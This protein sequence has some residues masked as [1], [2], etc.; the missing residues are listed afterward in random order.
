MKKS[1]IFSILFLL[2]LTACIT[3]ITIPEETGTIQVFF[4]P[5]DNCEQVMIDAISSASAVKCAFYDLDLENLTKT[6]KEKNADILMDEDN[7]E[8]YGKEISGYGLMHN[9]F[10]ILDEK[11]IITG[12]MNPTMRGAYKNNNNLVIIESPTLVNNYLA[13]FD[14][15]KQG[16]SDKKT[17]TTELI[18]N[19]RSLQNFFCPDDLCEEK[20]LTELSKANSSIYFLT[21]SFTSDPIGDLLVD[22]RK[23]IQIK[24]IFEKSQNSKWS[25]RKNSTCSI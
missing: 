23:D 13:E 17:K 25:E 20:V 9:K 10:C 5:K 3:E 12:S 8:G 21:F 18:Y 4:C 2:F 24:G 22:K 14:E 1:V 7:Y 6:L 19:N 15:L 11:I 16:R